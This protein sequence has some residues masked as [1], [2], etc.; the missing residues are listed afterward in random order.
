MKK[1]FRVLGYFLLAVIMIAAGI[2]IYIKTALPNVGAA[3]V[4][5]VK[6]SL[7]NI[8]R[9]RYLANNVS[10]CMDCHST[11]DWSKF[12]APVTEGT[13]GRGGERFD[14]KEGFPG[15]Y[16]SKNITPAGISRYTDGELFRL[17]TTGVTKEGRAMFPVMPYHYYGQ[18]DPEDIKCIIAYIRTL[19]P[20]DNN[21]VESVSDFPM[22]FII[23]TIPQKASPHKLPAKSDQFTYGAYMAN[24]SACIE[25][26]SPVN[27]GQ[28]ITELSFS[29]GREFTLPDGSVVRSA[30]LTPDKETGIG[31]WNED[32]FINRFKM[33]SDT[34]YHP[35]H[36]KPGE[37]N[38]IMPWLMY[39][40]MNKV[41]LAAIYAY[42]R[43]VKSI[44]NNVVKFTPT[45]N[46]IA[47][48]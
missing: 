5:K 12:L 21:V 2:L 36:I 37:F 13:T 47:I 8:E 29:G 44:K 42:L 11:R 48:K 18:M 10:V 20:I 15:I 23:N 33:Y 31:G 27:K 35:Q 46:P 1:V 38:S 6:N 17:I 4:L 45:L 26:H 25:C 22:N 3:P 32:Q 24:A 19:S 41:D 43:R 7:A 30:N 14:K 40:K 16:Y 34:S 39:S 9:G 28:I